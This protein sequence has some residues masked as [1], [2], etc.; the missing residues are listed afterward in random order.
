VEITGGNPYV[1]EGD[2]R[3]FSVAEDD[4]QYVWHRDDEDRYVEVLSGGGWQFQWENCLPWLIVPGM[5]IF[6]KANEYHRLLK[7]A[8]NLVVRITSRDK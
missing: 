6:I 7:G 8:D 2:V 1:D 4:S 5:Q 3:T